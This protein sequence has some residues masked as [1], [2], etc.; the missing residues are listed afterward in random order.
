MSNNFYTIRPVCSF[1]FLCRNQGILTAKVEQTQHMTAPNTATTDFKFLSSVG[2]QL[3]SRHWELPSGMRTGTVQHPDFRVPPFSQDT[4]TADLIVASDV[5]NVR[6]L[7]LD[8]L[9]E[10]S[11]QSVTRLRALPEIV[12]AYDNRI[13]V[14][15]KQAATEGYFLNSGS[16]ETFQRFFQ[17]KPFDTS[18]SPRPSGKW[19]SSCGLEG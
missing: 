6:F 9:D 7:L 11:W 13:N 14:L 17:K 5:Q 2:Q 19:Q 10:Y 16:K 4:E 15:E 18:R 3:A 12:S 8:S 1:L